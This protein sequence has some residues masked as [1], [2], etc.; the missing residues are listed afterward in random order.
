MA[1]VTCK[2]CD[3]EISSAAMMCPHCGVP[4]K[5][6]A[7]TRPVFQ[8][9]GVGL[10]T[11]MLWTAISSNR[12]S[13]DAPKSSANH[14]SISLPVDDAASSAKWQQEWEEVTAI[15]A[16]DIAKA[17]EENTV[18]ADQIYK[19]KLFKV[20]GV[21]T[22][23]N[24]DFAGDPYITM[25]GTNQFS[26]PHFS[27]SKGDLEQLAKLKK[28]VT[29]TLICKGGGDIAKTPMANECKLF[30]E[31]KAPSTTTIQEIKPPPEITKLLAK[32]DA[33]N[34]ICRGS[35]GD[36]QESINACD[37]REKLV[38]QAEQNGWCWGHKDDIGADRKWVPCD[39]QRIAATDKKSRSKINLD[40]IPLPP[41]VLAL[42]IVGLVS[43]RTPIDI[44]AEREFGNLPV[45]YCWLISGVFSIVPISRDN[46]VDP[47]FIIKQHQNALIKSGATPE[48]LE[49]WK[50][51]FYA[52]YRSSVSSSQIEQFLRPKCD[53]LP[54]K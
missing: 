30:R 5:Q 1:I 27:F 12:N 51:A 26:Q 28:G 53:A 8:V 19:K 25:D 49:V 48:D 29:I 54:Q 44:P 13:T 17:Y 31:T 22:N 36:S 33:A 6:K 45:N 18:A 50:K 46:K 42:D 43:T 37:L 41:E 10:M 34:D 52:I 4:I 47:S 20:R 16:T 35:P 38:T 2:E 32:I 9:L 21:V 24:T 7:K 15:S 14:P 39:E 23:I 40:T 3:K 11:L